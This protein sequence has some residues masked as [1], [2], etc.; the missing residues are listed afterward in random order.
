MKRYRYPM[1][2]NWDTTQDIGNIVPTFAQYVTPLDTWSG[3]Q[4]TVGRMSPMNK[5]VFG[6]FY[7]DQFLF[8]V[9]LQAIWN[10][11]ALSGY[12]DFRDAIVDNSVG[13]F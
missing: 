11:N 12:G 10:E 7:H 1:S 6:D 4:V 13:T 5:P 2:H 3:N 8:Y 9:P